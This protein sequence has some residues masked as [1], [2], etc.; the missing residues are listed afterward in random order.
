MKSEEWGTKAVAE[1]EGLPCSQKFQY[2]FITKKFA[3]MEKDVFA[4]YVENWN[5]IFYKQIA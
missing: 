4:L 2:N 3:I 5:I 1:E